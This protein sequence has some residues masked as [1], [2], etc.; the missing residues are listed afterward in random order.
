MGTGKGKKRD[1]QKKKKKEKGKSNNKL[2][3]KK[4]R[5]PTFWVPSEFH[6]SKNSDLKKTDTV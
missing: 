2:T 6:E 1:K 4:M 5:E 3:P